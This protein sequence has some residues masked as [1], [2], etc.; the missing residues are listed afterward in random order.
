MYLCFG[1]FRRKK[2][3][4]SVLVIQ[5]HSYLCSV[6]C[7][8]VREYTR[9]E[10]KLS[11]SPADPRSPLRSVMFSFRSN[12]SCACLLIN[13]ACRSADKTII[14]VYL[15]IWGLRQ[16]MVRLF[17]NSWRSLSIHNN[18]AVVPYRRVWGW[19]AAPGCSHNLHRASGKSRA[20]MT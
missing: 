18:T 3:K 8:I 6:A 1:F 16:W 14:S 19:G 10:A 4:K 13:S 7:S 17:L 15:K 20:W 9:P 11:C 5:Y 2:K 12:F